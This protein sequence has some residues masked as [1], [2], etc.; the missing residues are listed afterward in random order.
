MANFTT[1]QQFEISKFFEHLR[2]VWLD[3]AEE[4]TNDPDVKAM[5]KHDADLANI[6]AL[7]GEGM[8]PIL[9]AI[10]LGKLVRTTFDNYEDIFTMMEEYSDEMAEVVD[11]YYAHRLEQA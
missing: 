8:P 7:R 1:S 9:N 6:L 3:H 10:Q 11:A 2:D 5:L 4:E